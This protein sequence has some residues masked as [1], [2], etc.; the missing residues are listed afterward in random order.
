MSTT[1]KIDVEF[2]LIALPCVGIAHG[3]VLETI[4]RGGKA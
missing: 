1:V 4:L 3:A 2:D